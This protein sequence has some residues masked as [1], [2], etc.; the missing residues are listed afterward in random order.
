[1]LAPDE[2][3][4]LLLYGVH[5]KSN[6][7]A[8]LSNMH[9]R[10]AALQFIRSDSTRMAEAMPEYRWEIAV[11]GDMNV[12]PENEAFWSDSSLQPLSDWHDLW[13]G[14]SISERTTIPARMGDPDRMFPSA[15]FDRIIASPALTSSPWRMQPLQVLARGVNTNNI[16]ARTGMPDSDHVSDHYPVFTDI[17]R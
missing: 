10:Q 14:R 12:D 6:W 5:L 11:V 1:M 3:T 9:R 15:A 13:T 4:R 8:A 7:G 16:F 17:V 2:H